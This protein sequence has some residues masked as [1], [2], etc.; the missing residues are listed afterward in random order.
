MEE[1]KAKSA[2]CRVCRYLAILIAIRVTINV[3]I[4]AMIAGSGGLMWYLSD[5]KSLEKN[6]LAMPFCISALNSLLPVIFSL[7]TV[8]KR[9]E[10]P[11][12][13]VYLTMIRTVLLNIVTLGVLVAFW[14]IGSYKP[15]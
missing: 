10:N 7:F 4:L 9:Y 2:T 6:E 15:C 8:Y 14:Y 3:I 11:R 13:Q 12:I 1:S 5:T